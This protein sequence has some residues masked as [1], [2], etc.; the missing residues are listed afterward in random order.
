MNQQDYN[1][2]YPIQDYAIMVE[3]LLCTINQLA[4]LESNLN[5]NQDYSPSLE[6]A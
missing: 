4:S 6:Q 1:A 2:N 5:Q 3:A